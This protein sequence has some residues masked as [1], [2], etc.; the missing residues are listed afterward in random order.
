MPERDNDPIASTQMFRA[1]VQRDDAH[2]AG[3]LRPGPILLALV[4]VA[5][6]AVLLT[7]LIVH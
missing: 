4:L 2:P 3:R 7:W 6:V 5:A 1:F